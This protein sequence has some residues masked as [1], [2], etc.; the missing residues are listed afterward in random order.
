VLTVKRQLEYAGVGDRDGADLGVTAEVERGVENIVDNRRQVVEKVEIGADVDSHRRLVV[1]C[2]VRIQGQ[3]DV[4]F[5]V[6][7][8][9]R[10]VDQFFSHPGVDELID[11]SAIFT[12]RIVAICCPVLGEFIQ[13]SWA[14]RRQ[15]DRTSCPGHQ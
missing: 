2:R 8:S 5:A 14:G 4:D 15:L 9:P 11:K 6:L 3:A 13:R 10:T 1:Q 12:R 7:S